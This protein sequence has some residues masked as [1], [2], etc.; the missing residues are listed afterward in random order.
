MQKK[1]KFFA[2][3]IDFFLVLLYDINIVTIIIE[4]V[5]VNIEK[6]SNNGIPPYIRVVQSYYGKTAT[7]KYT[8]KKKLLKLSVSVVDSMTV[9]ITFKRLKKFLLGNN[10]L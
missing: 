10:I 5:Y 4:G 2:F 1:S 6:V 7:G 3:F 8:C 9:K